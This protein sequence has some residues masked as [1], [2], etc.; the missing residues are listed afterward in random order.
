LHYIFVVGH[1]E[2]FQINVLSGF[3]FG[4]AKPIFFT[5][6][7]TLKALN[8]LTDA[9]FLRILISKV[10]SHSCYFGVPKRFHA[11]GNMAIVLTL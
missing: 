11:L 6:D 5:I 1:L 4:L 9:A 8:D 2:L 7:I 3:F 10:L